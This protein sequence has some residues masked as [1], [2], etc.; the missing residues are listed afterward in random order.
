MLHLLFELRF[1]LLGVA[2]LGLATGFIAR[3]VG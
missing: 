1:L 3:K 2:F